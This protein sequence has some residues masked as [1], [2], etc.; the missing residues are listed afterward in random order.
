LG[1]FLGGVPE[2]EFPSK[3]IANDSPVF[4]PALLKIST[5]SR[6]MITNRDFPG[7]SYQTSLIALANDLRHEFPFPVA[8]A[9]TSG[10]ICYNATARIVCVQFPIDFSGNMQRFINNSLFSH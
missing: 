10:G 3:R 9:N 7:A 2:V 8:R 6:A 4:I 1:A 5:K